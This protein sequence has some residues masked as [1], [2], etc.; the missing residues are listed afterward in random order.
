[1]DA[2]EVLFRER[3]ATGLSLEKRKKLGCAMCGGHKHLT[4]HHIVPVSEGGPDIDE[5]MVW[6]C[7]RPCHD[8][9][10]HKHRVPKKSTVSRQKRTEWTQWAHRNRISRGAFL[11]ALVFFLLC[12]E[13]TTGGIP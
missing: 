12:V 13:R 2:N 7:R 8:N 3:V 10:H 5:N 1:M 6:L 11:E 9:I 4:R